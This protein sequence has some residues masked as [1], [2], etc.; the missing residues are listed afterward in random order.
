MF[1]IAATYHATILQAIFAA[2]LTTVD[3]TMEST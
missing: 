3:A 1:A 2:L